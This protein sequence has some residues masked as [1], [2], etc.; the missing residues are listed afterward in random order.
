MNHRGSRGICAES[1]GIWDQ[2]S[3]V[4]GRDSLRLDKCFFRLI[5]VMFSIESRRVC[6]TFPQS[7]LDIC[8]E[9][10]SVGSRT[11]NEMEER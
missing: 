8:E 4:T 1:R 2:L 3:L 11:Q 10:L 9:V 5:K 6:G 7:G